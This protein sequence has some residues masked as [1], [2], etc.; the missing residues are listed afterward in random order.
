[1]K[2]VNDVNPGGFP[3]YTS[4]SSAWRSLF[5]VGGHFFK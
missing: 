5:M 3:F 2:T 1:V 4:P